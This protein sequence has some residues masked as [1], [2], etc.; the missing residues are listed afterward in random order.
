LGISVRRIT[1]HPVV[2]DIGAVRDGITPEWL[3]VDSEAFNDSSVGLDKAEG[4]GTTVAILA[5]SV[6]EEVPPDLSEG[7]SIL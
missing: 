4:D 5:G 3:L 2:E 1:E 7:V 6:G